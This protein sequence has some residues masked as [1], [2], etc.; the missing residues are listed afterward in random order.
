MAALRPALPQYKASGTSLSVL[1]L[2]RQFDRMADDESD[3]HV[4]VFFL[5]STYIRTQIL[6]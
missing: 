2:M 6:D 3:L 1:K 5:L 4:A